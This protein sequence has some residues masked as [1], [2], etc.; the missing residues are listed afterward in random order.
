[1]GHLDDITVN[2]VAPARLHMGFI[3]MHGGLGRQFGSL[4]LSVSEIFLDLRVS[5]DSGI[6]ADGPD[7]VRAEQCANK[8][9]SYL[10]INNGVHIQINHTIPEHAGLGSGTQMALAVGTAI[11]RLYEM[12]YP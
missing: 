1:M 10:G 11:S 6:T 4:G 9:I 7:H 5:K 8:L 12:E 2:V 3:D